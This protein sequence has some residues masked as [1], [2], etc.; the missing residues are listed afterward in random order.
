M[1][2]IKKTFDIA[3]SAYIE[4]SN[5]VTFLLLNIFL[6]A[7]ILKLFLTINKNDSDSIDYSEQLK[8]KI[9]ESY[10]CFV[11]AYGG[12][13]NGD[14]LLPHFNNLFSFLNKACDSSLNPT[15]VKNLV[16]YFLSLQGIFK[17]FFGFNC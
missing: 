9:V 1:D 3:F 7:I 6:I 11:H 17:K 10:I 12:T 5:T 15:V 16:L 2:D 8:D 13:E 4:L 14:I